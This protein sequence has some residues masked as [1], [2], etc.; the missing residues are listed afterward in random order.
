M[1]KNKKKQHS[2]TAQITLTIVGLVAGTVYCAGFLMLP[3]WKAIIPAISRK[4]WKMGFSR[5]M[6]PVNRES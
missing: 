3:C 5:L 2:I 6:R 1:A 4:C